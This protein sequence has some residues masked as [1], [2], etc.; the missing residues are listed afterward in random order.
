[1]RYKKYFSKTAK[2]DFAILMSEITDFCKAHNI[3]YSSNKDSYYF[4]LNGKKYRV[5]NH[6]IE[7]SNN[8]AFNS[9]GVQTRR[10]YHAWDRDPDVTY[11]HASKTRLM[12]IYAALQDGYELDG[13]GHIKN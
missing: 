8:H 11:I 9:D 7:A 3:D 10:L 4:E 1:M 5:S 13:R 12:E 2:R 6:S